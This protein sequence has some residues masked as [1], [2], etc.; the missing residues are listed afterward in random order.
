MRSALRNQIRT[1]GVALAALLVGG[2]VV[3][4]I[5]GCGAGARPGG[6]T[7]ATRKNIGALTF[8]IQWPTPT[9]LIPLAA[10]SIE[11]R[12]F[13][14]GVPVGAPVF[15]NKPTDFTNGQTSVSKVQA[16]SGLDVTSSG[17]VYQVRAT[18]FPQTG[19]G[20]V[21]QAGG[22]SS[23]TLTIAAPSQSVTITM[24]STVTRLDVQPTTGS[25]MRVG[26]TRDLT[27]TAYNVSNAIVLIDP[28]KISWSSSNAAAGT[29]S[30]P[31]TGTTVTFTATGIAQTTLVRATYTEP[32]PNIVSAPATIDVAYKGVATT[33]WVKSR[34]DL[35]N[36]GQAASSVTG[37]ALNGAQLWEYVTGNSV[38][39]S[40]PSVGPVDPITG[41]WNI[42][43]GSYDGVLYC[44]DGKTG[45]EVWSYVTG[46][47]IDSSPAISREGVVYFGSLD[48]NVYALDAT[49][50]TLLWNFTTDGQVFSSPT[51]TTDGGVLVGSSGSGKTFYKLNSDDGTVLWQQTVGGSIETSPALSPSGAVVYFGS[52]DK[53]VYGLN[54]STGAAAPG[55]P[56]ATGDIIFGSSPAVD[57]AGNVYV[58]SFDGKLYALSSVG[59]TLWAF[60]TG[61]PIVAA[62]ALVTSGAGAATRI[63]VA[64]YDSNSGNRDSHLYA[65]DSGG[66]ELWRYPAVGS[67][68]NIDLVSSSPAIGKSGTVFFG[69]NDHSVYAISSTGNK[70]WSLDTG[71]IVE[72]SP[73][74]GP[75]GT[76]YLGGWNSKVFAIR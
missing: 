28:S 21:A 11:L 53:K 56:V 42:Y 59:A 1:A 25:S 12:L 37:E 10:N 68:E 61:S 67:G 44:L 33:S 41:D 19:G 3:M 55:W 15:V 54:V 73:A 36:T 6:A 22:Q 57:G 2:V 9:R 52:R 34:S 30:S 58:G 32:S 64:S 69:S 66:N 72:S 45:N 26:T 62:P 51:L 5:G 46:G 29:L 20:G 23:T 65:L 39:F 63:Y 75:D 16:F 7:G 71:N 47:P 27:A 76:I 13:K 70:V 14:A 50:G 35:Q 18:A 43:V 48:G 74:T 40:S 60:D 4:P 49:A 24:G 8:E 31:P 17:V 38:V